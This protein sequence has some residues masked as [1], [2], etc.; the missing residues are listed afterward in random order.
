MRLVLD[1]FGGLAYIQVHGVRLPVGVPNYDCRLCS[2]K[3]MFVFTIALCIC[4]CGCR[5]NSPPQE[6]V[7]T[8]TSTTTTTITTSTTTTT[9]TKPPSSVRLYVKNIMQNP[10]LPTGCEITS[11]TILLNYY[12]YAVNKEQMCEY[13]PQ[14][15]KFYYKDGILIGPDTNEYFVGNPRTT[16]GRALQCFAPVIEKTINYYFAESQSQY[17][18]KAI[19]GKDLEY[20][21]SYLSG[22]NPVCVWTTI[23]M[24]KAAKVQGWYNDS[25]ELVTS[26]RN[27]H[28]LV[29][30]GYDEQ[31]VYV[32][33]PLGQFTKVDKV[34]FEDRYKSVGSQA[35]VLGCDDLP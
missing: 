35:V 28:C 1:G 9:T 4:L 17:R 16:S 34:L 15:N 32:A 26:Y 27:L 22:G 25:M 19:V 11:A 2:M 7:A 3:K 29:M 8:T 10:E 31:Y 18:A 33:D 6:H 24:V 5:A 30:T 23:G 14:S 21:Y 20:F 12:G 13:L